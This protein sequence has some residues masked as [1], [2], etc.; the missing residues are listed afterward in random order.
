MNEP[1][2]TY[3]VPQPETREISTGVPDSAGDQLLYRMA[4][5]AL[6]LIAL[7]VAIGSL[8]LAGLGVGVPDGVIALGSVALG[9]L[10]GMLVPRSK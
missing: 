2:L 3:T 9:A 4:V 5:G 10:A 8:V 6:A 1:G 7:V